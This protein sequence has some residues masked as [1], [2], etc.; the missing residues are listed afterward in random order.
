MK[1]RPEVAETMS[2]DTI[3]SL[4]ELLNINYKY[5]LGEELLVKKGSL[6]Y[7]VIITSR[8]Y[9]LTINEEVQKAKSFNLYD[10]ETVTPI[11][12]EIMKWKNWKEERLA[13]AVY[14][15]YR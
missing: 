1:V 8:E 5:E 15:A 3:S 14:K 9:E 4:T 2:E 11:S 10:F 12:G 13:F 7:R 6:A